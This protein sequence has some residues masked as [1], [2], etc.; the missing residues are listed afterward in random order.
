LASSTPLDSNQEF[1]SKKQPNSKICIDVRD[2]NVNRS[3]QRIYQND[4][5]YVDYD[6]EM[7]T[8]AS[9]EN[10]EDISS[11]LKIACLVTSHPYLGWQ[12]YLDFLRLYNKF[13][14][15]RRLNPPDIKSCHLESVIY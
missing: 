14:W 1:T 2:L 5:G 12:E 9:I 8:L 4:D 11:A 10:K 3:I 13:S 6:K 15:K 7:K